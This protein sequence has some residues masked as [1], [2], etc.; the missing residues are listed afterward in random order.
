MTIAVDFDGTICENMFPDCGPPNMRVINKLIQ[1]RKEGNKLILWTCRCDEYLQD[2]IDYCK[3]YGLEFDCVNTNTDRCK[4][5]FGGN[6]TRKV[7][8]DYYL[9]D[10]ALPVITFLNL[11]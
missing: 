9:D 6:D 1:T 7:V 4:A 5:A 2:A 8:A 3:S 10:R 11:F